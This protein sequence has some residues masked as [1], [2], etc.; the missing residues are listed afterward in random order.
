MATDYRQYLNRDLPLLVR[1]CTSKARFGSRREARA[2][3]KHGRMSDGSLAP[4]HCQ[5]CGG[6][7]LGHR[8]R[9]RPGA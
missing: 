2:L 5:Y 3:A 7:H 4:Y 8:R 1:G 9:S 6:W